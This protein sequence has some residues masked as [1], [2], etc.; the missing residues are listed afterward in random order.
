MHT[1]SLFCSKQ[2]PAVDEK[3]ADESGENEPKQ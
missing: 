2:L 1:V 3:E